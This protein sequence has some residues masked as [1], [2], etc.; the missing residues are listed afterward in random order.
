VIAD[1]QGI[2]Q[3]VPLPGVTAERNR[4]GTSN[5]AKLVLGKGLGFVVVEPGPKF[6]SERSDIRRIVPRIHERPHGVVTFN[7]AKLLTH[8]PPPCVDSTSLR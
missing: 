2:V 8:D 6:L 7:H 1:R 5:L 3:V 4:A